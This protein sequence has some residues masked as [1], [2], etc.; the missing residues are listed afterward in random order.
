MTLAER[1]R[2]GASLPERVI[3]STA[4][5]VGGTLRES[6][7]LLLPATVRDARTYR[8]FIGQMLDF[9]AEDMGG[10]ER[11]PKAGQDRVD[12][13]VARKTVGNFVE[14]TSLA[15]IHMSPL[16]ILALVA[17]V[18]YGSQA[19]LREFADELEERGVIEDGSAIQR[20]DDLLEALA[21]ASDQ[22]AQTFDTPPL[23]I[24]GLRETIQQTRASLQQVDIATVL[25]EVELANLWQGI[26]DTASREG[27]SALDVSGL[28]A[29]SSIERVGRLRDGVLSSVR[30]AGTLLD[31]HVIDHYRE[32][33]ADVDERGFYASF[34]AAGRPYAEA[35]WRNFKTDQ[36]TLTENF[37][38]GGGL[39]RMAQSLW[40]AGPFGRR[41]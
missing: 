18:A 39:K 33:L 26:R 30:V 32:V 21:G 31:R 7:A 11:S 16:L 15:T 14:L 34:R 29:L 2:Y 20:T 12:G 1:L 13:F 4:G 38:E 3:R 24:D 22:M 25:P 35:A 9:M 17:D 10:V 37:I 28:I 36:R 19:Y 5:L 6:A 8:A 23:S 27:I 41:T 40:R